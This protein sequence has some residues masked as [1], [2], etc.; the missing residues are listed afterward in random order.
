[1]W[2]RSALYQSSGAYGFRDQLQDVMAVVYSRPDVARQ[3]IVLAASRQYHEG[4]V[5]H[6]WHPPEGRGTRTRFSDDFLFLPFVVAHYVRVTGDAS[7]LDEPIPFL[8]SPPLEYHEQ[9][10]YELPEVSS[11]EASLYQHCQRAIG[12]GMRYGR[13]GLP[14]MGCGDWNDGMNN[15]GVGGEGESVWVGWFQCAVLDQFAELARSRG[16]EALAN[17]YLERA[18]QLRDD[19]E[20]HGWDGSWY[21]RAFFDD[22]TP[23][24]SQQNDECQIDSLTQSWAVIA[25]GNPMRARRAMQSAVEHLVRDEDRLV[26]LFTPPFDKTSLDPGYIKGYLPGIREN[27]GQYTHAAT[28]LI[29]AAAMLGDGDLA[30]RLLDIIN[31]VHHTAD[32]GGVDRY[33][34]EPY[35]MAADVYS[36]PPHVG[37]GGWT[38]YTGT[39]AW[40]YRVIVESILGLRIDGDFV[41]LR[42]A[43]PASW[44]GFTLTLRRGNSTHVFQIAQTCEGDSTSPNEEGPRWQLIDDGQRHEYS[45]RIRATGA[46]AEAEA[47]RASGLV[48]RSD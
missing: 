46:E 3:H 10:R 18:A 16:D 2:G 27:G 4:D 36:Q 35:V 11:Q 40:T 42:P 43:I 29:Q 9:E 20:R 25:G 48:P 5:Q 47:Y 38:W 12:H 34:V 6:W 7:I 1:M 21:R 14:L 28:W 23:L 39:A 41:E 22:G 17:D 26:L 30:I 37:R 8:N 13:H 44:P 45:Y 24:G 15:V 33:Q 31:P 19:I 32:A